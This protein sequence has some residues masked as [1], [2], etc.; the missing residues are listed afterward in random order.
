MFLVV[1]FGVMLMFRALA[2]RQSI[3]NK[4]FLFAISV[5]LAL[6]VHKTQTKRYCSADEQLTSKNIWVRM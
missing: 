4:V 2:L 5:L 1:T 3:V 6:T